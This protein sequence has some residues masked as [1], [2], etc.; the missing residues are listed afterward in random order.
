MRR[1]LLHKLRVYLHVQFRL[2]TLFAIV[3]LPAVAYLVVS[4]WAYR[5]SNVTRL[6]KTLDR[7]PRFQPAMYYRGDHFGNWWKSTLGANQFNNRILHLDFGNTSISDRNLNAFHSLNGLETLDLSNTSITDA[8]LRELHDLVN[9]NSLNVS[10]T[11]ITDGGLVDLFRFL[12]N[13]QYIDVSNTQVTDAGLLHV[14]ATKRVWAANLD[15]TS[16]TDEGIT[17]LAESSKSRFLFSLSIS[18]TSVTDE[19]LKHIGRFTILQYL[20]LRNTDVS[21]VGLKHLT[22]TSLI[23]D[24]F[25]EGTAVTE[26][27]V[28]DYLD[29]MCLRHGIPFDRSKRRN[30]SVFTSEYPQELWLSRMNSSHISYRSEAEQE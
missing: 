25:L 16:V 30:F 6:A 12:P 18:D 9:L 4:I 23:S 1:W 19:G 21:D 26:D 5:Q 22:D 28:L 11:A 8:G 14:G 20:A 2:R 17:K 24:L 29:V 10:G 15:G 27:A 7:R 13:L 3:A